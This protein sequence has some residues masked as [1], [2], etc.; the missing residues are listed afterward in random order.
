[1]RRLRHPAAQPTRDPTRLA[2][3]VRRSRQSRLPRLARPVRRV[4]P[5]R[6]QPAVPP[7][8]KPAWLERRRALPTR[9]ARRPAQRTKPQGGHCLSHLRDR[10][11][12]PCLRSLS[13]ARDKPGSL[14]LTLRLPA[15]L[16]PTAKPLRPAT[17]PWKSLRPLGLL[18]S[19]ARVVSQRLRWRWTRA[20][21]RFRSR[22]RL[23][24]WLLPR[25][26]LL[27]LRRP[28]AALDTNGP[29]TAGTPTSTMKTTTLAVTSPA[30]GS[31]GP[32]LPPT[33]TR[34][35]TTSMLS[36]IEPRSRRIWLAH[37]AKEART[38]TSDPGPMKGAKAPHPLQDANL[39]G[40]LDDP[41]HLVRLLHGLKTRLHLLLHQPQDHL[42]PRPKRRRIG[43]K[44]PEEDGMV[45]RLAGEIIVTETG[46]GE[47]Y[48]LLRNRAAKPWRNQCTHFQ[49]ERP[50]T[51]REAG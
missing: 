37:M 46:G 43:G 32:G 33:R 3:P 28:L 5:L 6:C 48:L 29:G 26:R 17:V 30:T 8:A 12:Q 13:T 24:R 51:L 9:R 31:I 20:M 16:L 19:M 22:R 27:L 10:A 14:S 23:P 7:A 47:Q 45:D 18:S 21:A 50:L 49:D 35:G 44:T 41:S 40:Q 38:R 25:R 4:E 11:A 1:M 2:K 42:S 15:R 39:N 36:S 34:T